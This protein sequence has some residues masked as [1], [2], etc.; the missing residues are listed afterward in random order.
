MP[1]STIDPI[2]ATSPTSTA[3][4]SE[5]RPAGDGIGGLRGEI[6]VDVPRD[7]GCTGV[8]R[9]SGTYAASSTCDDGDLNFQEYT[10]CSLRCGQSSC[11]APGLAPSAR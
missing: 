6:A 2:A 8:R 9:L 3:R 11:L 10:R 4:A 1:L 7:H 5:G